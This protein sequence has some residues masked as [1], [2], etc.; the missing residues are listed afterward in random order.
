MLIKAVLRYVFE[1]GQLQYFH[2]VIVVA[3]VV[4]KTSCKP[5]EI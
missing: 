2:N 4:K 3:K 5:N 1:T